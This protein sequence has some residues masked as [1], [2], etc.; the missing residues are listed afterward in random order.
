MRWSGEDFGVRAH[1]AIVGEADTNLP[2]P[3]ADAAIIRHGVERRKQWWQIHSKEYPRDDLPPRELDATR[4]P[5]PDFVLKD[6]SGKMVRLSD[7]RGKVVL[8]NFWAT[9]CTAC[10]A[11]IADLVA[12]QKRVGERVAIVGVALDGVPNE[13]DEGHSGDGAHPE[14][15]APTLEAITAKV[16]RAVEAR[17]INYTVLLDPRSSVGG[18]FNGEELPTTII[19]DAQGR[20]RRR[21]VGERT[22]EVFEAMLAEAAK[23]LSPPAK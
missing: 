14:N 16:A 23:P 15:L 1:M 13:H 3:D 7:F 10:L 6:L 8:V 20:V 5:A 19:F 9:W 17:G 11:E 2:P 4:A 12:L 21:F 18:R 22:L